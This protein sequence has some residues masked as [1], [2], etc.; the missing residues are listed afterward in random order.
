MPDTSSKTQTRKVPVALSHGE[1][2]T[3]GWLR[4][5][6]FSGFSL[7]MMV[8]LVL[9]VVVLAPG[10]RVLVEQR[11]EIAALS[12]RVE[13]QLQQVESLR[14]ERERWNDKTYVITQARDRLYYV[15]PGE[16]SFLVINDLPAPV[17]ESER[18]PISTEIQNTQLD[19]LQSM[20]ASVMTAGLAES[21][22]AP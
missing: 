14:A 9:A 2:A 16:V 18:A 6:R 3:G 7:I 10:L 8:M 19:W 11:Q 13:T 22:P 17:E 12:A 1:S 15:M 5:I 4:G 20:F 21:A